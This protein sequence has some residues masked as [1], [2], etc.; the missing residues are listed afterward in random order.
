MHEQ[1]LYFGMKYHRT[2]KAAYYI[3]SNIALDSNF[4]FVLYGLL[5]DSD[6]SPL[7]FWFADPY[8]HGR[9]FLDYEGLGLMAIK[10]Q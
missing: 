10:M 2:M 3:P 8:F 1:I 5:C 9:L 4:A 7:V 6:S